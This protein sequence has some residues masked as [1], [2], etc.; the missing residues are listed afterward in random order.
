MPIISEEHFGNLP[1]DFPVYFFETN[2]ASS[3]VRRLHSHKFLEMGL[4]DRNFDFYHT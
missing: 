3:P 1:E 2:L 4:T